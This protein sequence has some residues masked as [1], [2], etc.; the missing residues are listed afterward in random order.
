MREAGGFA[1][2]K[3]PFANGTR[4][5]ADLPAS[6]HHRNVGGSEVAA[7]FGVQPP[8]E[9]LAVRDVVDVVGPGLFCNNA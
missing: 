2:T 7:L 5:S 9:P 3:E 4:A 8:H 1:A 6:Q